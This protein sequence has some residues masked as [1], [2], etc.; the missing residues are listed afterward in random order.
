MGRLFWS[1]QEKGKSTLKKSEEIVWKRGAN[2][3]LKKLKKKIFL[4][5]FNIF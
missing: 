3:V 1:I 4:L 2:R 5:K